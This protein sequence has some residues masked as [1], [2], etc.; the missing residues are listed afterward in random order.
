MQTDHEGES[1]FR[2][3]VGEHP[4]LKRVIRHA[5]EVAESG[6]TALIAGEAGTGKELIARAIHR[7]GHRR[8]QSFVKID[9]SSVAPARLEAAL[10]GHNRGCLESANLGTLL[11][12]S[13][14]SIPQDLQPKLL[15][16]FEQKQFERPGEATILVDVCLIATTSD[17]RQRVEDSWLYKGLSPR[18]NVSIIRVPALRERRSDIPLLAWY[19]VKTWARRMKKSI[20]TISPETMESFVNYRWPNNVK[21]MEDVIERSVS[22]TENTE[23]RSDLLRPEQPDS[24][25]S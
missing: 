13:V 20:E 7:M 9:C 8:R 25:A 5:R 19:F 24:A 10:F 17:I 15:Q 22:L 21:E 14:E 2:E 1:A 18:L 3:V 16:V 23:L 11:L 6:S 12:K 4:A